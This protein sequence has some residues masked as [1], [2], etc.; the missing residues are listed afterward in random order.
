MTFFMHMYIQV[1]ASIHVWRWVCAYTCGEH[2]R[3]NSGEVRLV[4][5]DKL[6]RWDLTL[7]DVVVVAGQRVPGALH[8]C[9]PSFGVQANIPGCLYGG[10]VLSSGPE[11]CA[12]VSSQASRSLCH[13]MDEEKPSAVALA[14]SYNTRR[15]DMT[16]CLR[17]Q[18]C[19]ELHSKFQ[20]RLDSGW[21][22][23]SNK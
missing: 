10:W 13:C 9:S 14:Y 22:K 3:S 7:T 1:C 8:L 5:C 21:K 12:W 11:A 16:E 17:V 2:R 18:S 6:S 4:F 15:A 23:K 20:G 19:C